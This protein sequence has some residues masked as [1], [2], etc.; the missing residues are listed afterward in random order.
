MRKLGIILALVVSIQAHSQYISIEDIVGT[1]PL[2]E[3]V[4]WAYTKPVRATFWEKHGQAIGSIAWNIGTVAIGAVGDGVYDNGN[5]QLGHALKAAEVG[6]LISGPFVL[7]LD[8]WDGIPYIASYAMIR[9][10]LF[11]GFY[12]ASR[13]LPALNTGS[14][15]YYDDVTSKVPPHGLV[16]AKS[17]MLIAGVS[18]PIKEF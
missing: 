15:S 10:A 14:T 3:P 12:N 8:K 11:D 9:F 16:F 4:E 2:P 17:I 7:G 1:D 18:I 6:M 13:G 5:K